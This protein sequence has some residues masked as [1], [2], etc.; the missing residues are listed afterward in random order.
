MNGLVWFLRLTEEDS[1]IF[2]DDKQPTL[3]M[4]LW[5]DTELKIKYVFYK[6]PI[7]PNRVLQ[8]DTAL[9]EATISFSLT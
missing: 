2:E 3:D 5:V 9:S 1:S 6:K 7:V 8:Q 4:S